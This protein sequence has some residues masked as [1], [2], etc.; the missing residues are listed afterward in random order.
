MPRCLVLVACLVAGAASF[1]AAPA[2]VVQ[3]LPRKPP[4]RRL[5][6]PRVCATAAEEQLD[7]R[8]PPVGQ[9]LQLFWRL[10]KPFFEQCEGAKLALALLIG[11][12]LLNSGV[13]VLFSYV[14]RDLLNTLAARDLEAFTELIGRFALA[15]ALATP[16]SVLFKFQRGRVSLLWREWM[17]GVLAG[18]YAN[19]RTFYRLEVGCRRD[20]G[21]M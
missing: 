5:A 20:M 8:L 12:T 10:S 2:I 17:F 9:Q 16:V 1:G 15:L 7:E 4:S 14:S 19:E 6:V 13:A 18:L 11:L 21:E 3:R